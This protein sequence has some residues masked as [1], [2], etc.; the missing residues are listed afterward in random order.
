MPTQARQLVIEDM[1]PM[2]RYRIWDHLQQAE[3]TLQAG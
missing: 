2:L 1:E 3:A